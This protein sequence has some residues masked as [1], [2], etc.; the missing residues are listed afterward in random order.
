MME[1]PHKGD[2]VLLRLMDSCL[3]LSSWSLP[4]VVVVVVDGDD[5]DTRRRVL[6]C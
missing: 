1:P 3:L 4:V 2:V 6:V 5:D